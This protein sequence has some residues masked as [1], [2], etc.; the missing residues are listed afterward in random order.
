MEMRARKPKSGAARGF[1]DNGRGAKISK[2]KKNWTKKL[3]KM[4][5]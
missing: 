1:W 2:R 3:L 4:D 5:V